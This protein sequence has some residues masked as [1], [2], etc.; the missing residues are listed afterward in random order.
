MSTTGDPSM[1]R[2]SPPEFIRLNGHAIRVTSWTPLDDP[3]SF[4]LVTIVRGSADATLLADLLSSQP[5]ELE[6]PGEPLRPIFPGNVE[7]RDTGE[8][9]A[10]I[11][12]ISVD[13]LASP[14]DATTPSN[15][16]P[17]LSL[18]RRVTTLEAEVA[19]LKALVQ[20]LVNTTR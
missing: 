20:S 2:T 19:T 3:G 9:P 1:T 16:E 4:R 12:R 6:V 8:P 15:P 18:E 7:R 17:V 14:S 11:T 10:T 13:L 5:L